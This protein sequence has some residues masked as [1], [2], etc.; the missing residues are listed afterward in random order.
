MDFR[1]WKLS[2]FARNREDSIIYKSLL[3]KHGVQVISINEP[4]DDS[5][6]GKLLEGMIEVIDEFYSTNLSEDTVRGMKENVERGFRSGGGVPF[7]YRVAKINVGGIQKSKLEPEE[8]EAP[9]SRRVFQMCLGGEGGKDIAKALNRGGLRTRAGKPWGS[10]T[11]NYMLRNEAY[12]GVLVWAQGR[13]ESLFECSMPIQHLSLG[14]SS[15]R[16][17]SF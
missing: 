7:G 3:R 12:T 17:S 2:R 16:C 13:T 15:I 9:I 4:V 10:T 8:A 5:A 6:A 11:I 1:F 14:K